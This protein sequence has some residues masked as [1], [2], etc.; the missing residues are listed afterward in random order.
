M[1][2]DGGSLEKGPPGAGQRE[3][4]GVPRFPFIASAKEVDVA[5]HTELPGRV[6]EISEKG[7]FIDTLNPFPSATRITVTIDHHEKVFNATGKVIY[8]IPNMG[9]G[10]VFTSMEAKDAEILKGWLHDCA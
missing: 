9:M 10:I 8:V 1:L 7:C 6:S 5:T 4:R 3:R 2:D